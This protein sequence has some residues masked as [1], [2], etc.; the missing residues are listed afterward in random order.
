MNESKAKLML[1]VRDQVVFIKINGRGDFNLSLDLRK[2]IDELRRRS[3]CRFVFE[4]SECVMMDSTFLGILSGEGLKSCSDNPAGGPSLELLNPIPR[5]VETLE[6]LGV[7]HLFK[8][9]HCPDSLSVNY[10]SLAQT[11]DKTKTE[12]TRN[13]LD[14]HKTLMDVNPAN[15][16]RFKD[17]AEFLAQDLKRL[18]STAKK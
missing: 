8:I 1:A 9:T 13:C 16:H 14:A 7:A 5:I 12:V 3:Y 4:L 17:V 11:E 15:V 18:E 2:L 10:E 6:N